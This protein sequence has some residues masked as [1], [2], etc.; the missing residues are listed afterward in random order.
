M[1]QMNGEK[2]EDAPASRKSVIPWKVMD[3][4]E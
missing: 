4:E 1:K 3:K 2:V